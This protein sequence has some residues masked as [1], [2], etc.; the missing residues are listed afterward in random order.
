MSEKFTV[1]KENQNSELAP[2]KG[3]TGMSLKGIVR[4]MVVI[5]TV[6]I[7]VLATCTLA[8]RLFFT[9][10]LPSQ[11]SASVR[12]IVD[13]DTPTSDSQTSVST[14]QQESPQNSTTPVPL[15]PPQPEPIVNPELQKLL[16][17]IPY[18]QRQTRDALVYF[19]DRIDSLIELKP[20]I[21]SLVSGQGKTINA[22]E[23]RMMAIENALR[24]FADTLEVNN[25]DSEKVADSRPPFN[26]IAVD[27]WENQWNAVI[28]LDGRIT[29]IQPEDS[30]AGWK[31]LKIN[32]STASAEFHS[33]SGTQAILKVN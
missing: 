31:L 30:R 4:R 17:E 1:E 27:R 13:A 9:E 11:P 2:A 12:E 18:E 22:L 8:Y 3:K 5:S 10:P 29:M 28:E 21:E 32:P 7:A 33:D 26:L 25:T 23:T 14:L 24:E 19:D 6:I 16:S 20:S 15:Q